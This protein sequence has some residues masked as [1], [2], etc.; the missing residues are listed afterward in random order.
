[1]RLLPDMATLCR[2]PGANSSTAY[3][4][5]DTHHLDGRPW[6]VSPRHVLKAVIELYRQRGWR[7]VVAP[8]MEFYLTAPNPNPEI[9]LTAPIGASGR[10]ETVQHPY[11]LEALDDYGP[12]IERIY[13]Y[14]ATASLTLETLTHES[15][16]GQ[17][18]INFPHGD[19]LRLADQVVLFKRLARQAAREHGMHATFMA[20]PIAEHAGSSMH[21]HMSVVDEASGNNL[22]ADEDGTDSAAFGHFI[23]GLQKYLPEITPLMAPNVNS[24]RRMR[25][26]HSAPANVE[27]AR[28]NRT[29]GL[30]VPDAT[31]NARRVENRLPGADA[32]P[33]LAIAGSL[34]AGYLGIEEKIERSPEA[35]GNAYRRAEHLAAH[36]GGRARPAGRL[37]AGAGAARRAVH[38]DLPAPQG[39][40]ARC[41]PERGHARGS[42]TIC[43]SRCDHGFQ[44]RARHREI[45][46]CGD[47]QS[48]AELSAARRRGRGRPRGGRRRLHRPVG[49]TARRRAR[50]EGRAA[51]RR[52]DRL[53]RVGPQWRPDHP[54]PAQ[55]RRRAGQKLTG[56]SGRGR[57][58]TS[59]SR[60]AAWCLA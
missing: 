54:R 32:N 53:G 51:R 5:A 38:A 58:S 31:Q 36:H 4:F 37:P 16:P 43:C 39:G 35:T 27:W 11:G 48:G 46:L 59:P 8:E 6:E 41:V 60:R 18:E 45:L 12:V 24:F 34:I 55:G 13:E 28:D 30:R 57:C 3:V 52:Q 42:A 20:K 44:F 56:A 9:A 40:R 47:G 25:P 26:N 2:A 10:A 50:A 23:G 14:A 21:L 1:M 33:Y 19:P 17:L 22:F 15:G 7:A 29:C 49:G